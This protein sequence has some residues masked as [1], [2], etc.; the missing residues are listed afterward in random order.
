VELAIR[1]WAIKKNIGSSY[2]KL[3][4]MHD[5]IFKVL[6]ARFF[7]EQTATSSINWRSPLYKKKLGTKEA[8][9]ITSFILSVS[10]T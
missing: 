5:V 2:A 4:D 8:G 9:Q 6:S 3:T 10:F 1:G 7:L